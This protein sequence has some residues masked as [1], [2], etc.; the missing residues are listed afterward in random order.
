MEK[1]IC[2]AT[3]SSLSRLHAG[4]Q[5]VTHGFFFGEDSYLLI[6]P[7]IDLLTV[8]YQCVL[9]FLLKKKIKT[10]FHSEERNKGPL[11]I[12]ALEVIS[13]EWVLQ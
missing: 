2:N 1:D 8:I 12:L 6:E 7:D 9:T 3:I 10:T 11:N 5:S 4:L 13:V